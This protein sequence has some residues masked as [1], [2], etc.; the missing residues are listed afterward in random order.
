[1]PPSWSP[2]YT[3]P[4]GKTFL[5]AVAVIVALTAGAMLLVNRLTE[6]GPASARAERAAAAAERQPTP[7]TERAAQAYR[8]GD[9]PGAAILIPAGPPSSE[10]VQNEAPPIQGPPPIPLPV[11]PEER[12]EA[13]QTIRKDRFDVQMMRLNRR[14]EER[15]AKAANQAGTPPPPNPDTQR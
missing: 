13:L 15:A 12:K 8:A 2:R 3:P 7:D 9:E 4:V 1:M 14:G 6:P 10:P 11:D 5:I